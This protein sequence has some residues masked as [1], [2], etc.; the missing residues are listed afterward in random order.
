MEWP[1]VLLLH[2][3][4]GA[5]RDHWQG[6]LAHE[7]ADAGATVE[8]PVFS[9]PDRPS[10]DVWLSELT[11]HLEVAPS[12]AKR[13]VVA[14]GLGAA[15]WLH[16][17]ARFPADDHSLRVDNV[18]LVAPPGA[19]WHIPDV[20]GFVPAPLDAAGIRRAA[21]WTQ[22]ATGEDDAYLPVDEAVAMAAALKIDLDVI[23]AGG[24][25]D[26]R[27]GYGPWPCVLEWIKNRHTRLTAVP[28]E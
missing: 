3:L 12:T 21:G 25:L 6:W 19:G 23:P 2:G 4:T 28:V 20:H 14:Q 15:L 24:S 26:T 8:V 5:G 13:V 10:L 1:Y 22:L 18:L 17:A 7:L 27:T 16:H 9:D 11:H